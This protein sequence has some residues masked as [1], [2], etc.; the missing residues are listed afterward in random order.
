VGRWT[1]VRQS[2]ESSTHGRHVSARPYSVH[3]FAL[4]DTEAIKA[5]ALASLNVGCIAQNLKLNGEDRRIAQN[6]RSYGE[7]ER[8][9][10]PA[11]N[12]SP[13]PRSPVFEARK[14]CECHCLIYLHLSSTN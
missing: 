9:E 12:R 4:M 11:S 10:A 1:G 14:I 3:A 13:L 7:E 5:L 6:P 2:L 8:L